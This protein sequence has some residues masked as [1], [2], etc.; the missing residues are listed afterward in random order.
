MIVETESSTS[1]RTVKANEKTIREHQRELG[2]VKFEVWNKDTFLIF[3][4]H[5]SSD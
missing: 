4:F 2:S 1:L 3:T 5:P